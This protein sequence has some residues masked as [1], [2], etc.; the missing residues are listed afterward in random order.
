M[1][2][3]QPGQW[4][5]R[6]LSYGYAAR[7]GHLFPAVPLIPAETGCT[8]SPLADE[9]DRRFSIGRVLIGTA[10]AGGTSSPDRPPSRTSD[11]SS[12][13]SPPPARTGQT[14]QTFPSRARTP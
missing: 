4:R 7:D 3:A 12:P 14:A 6:H 2:P 10:R 8:D 1:R 5:I 13:T 9:A 11:T